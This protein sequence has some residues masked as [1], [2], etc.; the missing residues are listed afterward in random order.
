MVFNAI[1]SHFRPIISYFS[2]ILDI[3]FLFFEAQNIYFVPNCTG[4]PENP[5]ILHGL[6][7]T[8]SETPKTGFLGSRLTCPTSHWIILL[9]FPLSI[10][11]L[12]S[13]K[14][15]HAIYIPLNPTFIQKNWGM[16]GYTYFSYFCSKT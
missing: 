9:A 1:K 12:S 10:S 2:P 13:G 11:Y 14:H 8:W 16:Q 3:N 7:Q 5:S 15:V 4:Q 6:C